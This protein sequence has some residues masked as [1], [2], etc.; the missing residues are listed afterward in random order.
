MKL[1]DFDS[2]QSCLCREMIILLGLMKDAN[3]F[4]WI[5]AKI[6]ENNCHNIVTLQTRGQFSSDVLCFLYLLIFLTINAT[7]NLR[8]SKSKLLQFVVV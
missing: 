2:K 3:F 4:R 8:S 6:A 5:L 7:Y 1:D